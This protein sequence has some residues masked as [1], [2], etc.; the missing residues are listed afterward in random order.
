MLPSRQQQPFTRHANVLGYLNIDSLIEDAEANEIAPVFAA[1]HILQDQSI[2]S[3]ESNASVYVILLR[4]HDRHPHKG[5]VCFQV[6]TA[7]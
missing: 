1:L 5:Q 6:N 7:L 3:Y 4:H 2:A